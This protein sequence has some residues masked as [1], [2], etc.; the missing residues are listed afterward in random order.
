MSAAPLSA[1]GVGTWGHGG[2]FRAD[3]S[4]D[5]DSIALLR[6]AFDLGLTV[7]DTAEAY[8]AG[9]CE[10]L[11]GQA[12]GPRRKDVFL[13]SKVSPEHLGARDLAEAVRGSLTRL[14]TEYLDLYQIHWP[15]PRIPLEETFE[16]LER[17]RQDGLIRHIGVSNFS[18]PELRR[19]LALCPEL[20]SVQNELNLFDRFAERTVLPLCR[21]HG[22]TLIAYSPLDQGKSLPGY[23]RHPVLSAVARR[24]GASVPQVM[25]AWL[26][27][28]GPVLPIA[29]TADPAH[30]ADNAAAV[31]VR[32]SPE[33]LGAIEAAFPGTP[34]ELDPAQVLADP[35]GLD[36]F[37]PGPE[38]LAEDIRAGVPVKPARVR[39]CPGQPGRYELIE[40]KL[41]FFAFVRAYDGKRPV[42]CLVRQP[43]EEGHHHG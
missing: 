40:G 42:P 13:A 11:L 19:A 30:L 29:R 20:F 35:G 36:T 24:H 31:D 4:R 2:F 26:L 22:L 3:R 43:Q 9:H 25:L 28:K 8:G 33:D 41:R 18:P 23:L 32:L 21:E 34:V 39:P 6:R 1:M 37:V 17:L 10:T 15:N 14:G 12:L 16:A 38:A 5:A 7:F 27:A